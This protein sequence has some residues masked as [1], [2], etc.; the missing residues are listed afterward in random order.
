MYLPSQ[1]VEDLQEALKREAK[2]REVEHNGRSDETILFVEDEENQ[3]QLMQRLLEK[4]GYRV[5][6]GRDGI[7]A[8]ELHGQHKDKIAAAVLDLGLPKL[9]GWEAFRKMKS[10]DPHL[11]AVFTSGYIEPELKLEMMK[12]GAIVCQKPYIPNELL[13]RIQLAIKEK[14]N[15]RAKK[16]R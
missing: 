7:E 15:P 13:N 10:D 1:P 8:V 2:V 12:E 3:I 11:T 9:G 6:I 14:K 4:R 16:Q 5:L